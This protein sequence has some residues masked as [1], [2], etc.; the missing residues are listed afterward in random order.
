MLD[1]KASPGKIKKTEIISSICSDHNTMRLEI[2]YKGKKKNPKH[3]H[4]ESKQYAMKQP[5]DY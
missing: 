1:H 4:L 3:K 5:M 2:N